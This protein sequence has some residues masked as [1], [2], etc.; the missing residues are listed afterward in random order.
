M[1]YVEVGG[2]RVSAIGL[3]TWQY[4]SREWGYGRDYAEHEAGAITRRALELGVNLI[5]T[6]R[7]Y[8]RS[9]E[10]V[11]EGLRQWS[12]PAPFVVLWVTLAPM[13]RSLALVVVAGPLSLFEPFPI[14]AAVPSSGSSASR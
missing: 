1:R 14:D 13:M 8:E 3:G 10:V 4:G 2:V 9:E 12:G 11:G 7:A 5:D 6:A